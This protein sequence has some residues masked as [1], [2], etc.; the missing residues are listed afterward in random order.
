MYVY[1]ERGEGVTERVHHL[2]EGRKANLVVA[3]VEHGVDL[4]Q[5]RVTNNPEIYRRN[6]SDLVDGITKTVKT[7]RQWWRPTS[8]PRHTAKIQWKRGQG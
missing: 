7:N 8:Q 5:E 2:S 4:G 1:F 3:V 6:V